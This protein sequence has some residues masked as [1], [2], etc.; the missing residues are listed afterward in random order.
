MAQKK[1]SHAFRGQVKA[2][3]S[4]LLNRLYI[5]RTAERNI[6]DQFHQLFYDAGNFEKAWSATT[7]LGVPAKKCPFDPWTYQEIVYDLRP[8]LLIES[9]TAYGGTALFLA[10]LCDLLNHG[11]V[12]TID[13]EDVRHKQ[14]RSHPRIE[15]LHGSSTSPDI[16]QQVR[17]RARG[18]KVS[19][20]ILDS[21][22]HRDHVLN[23]LRLYREFVT[24]GSYLVVEDTNMNGHPVLPNFGPGPMEAVEEFLKENTDFIIDK[25]RE[26]FYMTFNPGG[27][28]KKI[29]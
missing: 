13:I 6:V 9:G 4:L 25:T 26:K 27:Y 18:A 23:E 10:S 5:S 3:V 11:A 28:L 14:V 24:S 12:I 1:L 16:V 29:K 21:D 15:F 8:D 7:W 17:A 2:V 20:V 19:L 22:H